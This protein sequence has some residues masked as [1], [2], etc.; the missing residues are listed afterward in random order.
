MSTSATYTKFEVGTGE[1]YVT[2]F[3]AY[4]P[5]LYREINIM[6]LYV[7]DSLDGTM[8][9]TRMLK[10]AKTIHTSKYTFTPAPIII[11]EQDVL[12]TYGIGPNAK[13]T[14]VAKGTSLIPLKT[15][16]GYIAHEIMY[17]T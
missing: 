15:Q 14:D 16:I 7:D 13:Y 8:W 2:D 17:K 5:D 10:G 9:L 6:G 3:I 1:T 11:L 4:F 12:T